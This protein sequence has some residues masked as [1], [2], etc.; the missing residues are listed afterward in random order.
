MDKTSFEKAAAHLRTS[1]F[2]KRLIAL[3][4]VPSTNDLARQEAEKGAPEGTVVVAE[5]QTV[6][7]GRLSRSWHS[8]SGLGVW[9]S[10]VLRPE[11]S[12]EIAPSLTFCVS[13][14]VARAVRALH[15]VDVSLK[16]PNDVLVKGRKL[17]GILTEMKV[18]RDSVEYVISG[19]GINVN[20]TPEDFPDELRETATSILMATGRKADRVEL[21]SEVMEQMEAVYDR[22]S[23]EGATACI[24]EWRLMC[25]F[26]GKRVRITERAET[27]TGTES[28]TATGT[29]IG[30][31]TG[32][33]SDR[34]RTG[35]TTE[36]IFF[37]IE[38]NGALVLRLDSG[39]HRTFV[40][41][42]IEL[43][44]RE[45]EDV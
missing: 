18:V 24:S 14:A 9:M 4:S 17:C 35:E 29:R 28:M 2:G 21:F 31:G 11:V 13:L 40:A 41:G 43:V 6:G 44:S 5:E 30:T 37:D 45:R 20:Q 19:V 38:D 7:R 42:D 22:F 34:P 1:R 39:V 10:T 16:W 25:P 27:G 3:R 15:P 8:P 32:T 12:P 36:G 33:A 26:F 23:S